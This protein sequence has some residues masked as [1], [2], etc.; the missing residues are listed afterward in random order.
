MKRFI[1]LCALFAAFDVVGGRNFV[2]AKGETTVISGHLDELYTITEPGNYIVE[3]EVG[4][5]AVEASDVHLDLN[6][7]IVHQVAD[8][9]IVGILINGQTN[10][11]VSGPGTVMCEETKTVGILVDKGGNNHINGVDV[12]D[13]GYWGI[14]VQRSDA[15]KINGN[16]IEGSAYGISLALGEG[17]SVRGNTATK[18]GA[19]IG[20][21]GNLNNND[22]KGNVTNDNRGWGIYVDISYGPVTNNRFIGNTALNNGRMDL[23]DTNK[24][25]A[26]NTWLGNT[27]MTADPDCI[28]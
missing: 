11:H 3:G 7:G 10:V 8:V 28:K 1:I 5:I 18:C 23:E 6:G 20:L 16:V 12:I 2:L 17:N 21:D 13:C 4:P 15:N 24:N 22:F 26:A 27:F 14:L 19:G 25:C 9:S